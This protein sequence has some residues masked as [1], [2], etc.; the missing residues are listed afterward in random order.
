MRNDFWAGV[1]SGAMIALLLT[2]P[3]AYAAKV[4]VKAKHHRA[5]TAIGKHVVEKKPVSVQ[6][7]SFPDTQWRRSKSSAAGHRKKTKLPELN[8]R[9]RPRPP[10][11]SRSAIRAAN[12]SEWSEATRVIRRQCHAARTASKPNW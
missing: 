8:R 2:Q 9:K 4:A 6:I 12:R 3:H 5:A 7:V 10:K 11:P 1:I